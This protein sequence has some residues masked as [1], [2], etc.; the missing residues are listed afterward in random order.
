MDNKKKSI[1]ESEIQWTSGTDRP[2]GEIVVEWWQSYLGDNP[3]KK[4]LRK[5]SLEIKARKRKLKKIEAQIERELDRELSSTDALE[6]DEHLADLYSESIKKLESLQKSFT[7]DE[8][9]DHP[10]PPPDKRVK[11]GEKKAIQEFWENHKDEYLTDGYKF[12][13]SGYYN[14]SEIAREIKRKGGFS[15]SL[16]TIKEHAGLDDL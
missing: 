15:S 12:D 11:H 3:A 5:L 1:S 10:K 7:L 13:S 9:F 8:N 4:Q 16:D 14:Q 2:Y 6:P